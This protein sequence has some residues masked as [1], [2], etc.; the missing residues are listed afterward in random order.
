MMNCD[1][2]LH[3]ATDEKKSKSDLIEIHNRPAVFN[4]VAANVDKN[5][6]LVLWF[7]NDPLSL[8]G[9][10]SKNQ[11]VNIFFQQFLGLQ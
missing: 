9:S 7:H 11:R 5:K 2:F 4:Y 3:L 6:K 10:I 8:R 1:E